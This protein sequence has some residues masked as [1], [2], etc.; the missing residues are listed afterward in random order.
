MKALKEKRIGLRSLLR[1]GLVILSL[2]ALVFAFASCNDSGGEETPSGPS[3]P[4]VSR[5]KP[6]RIEIISQPTAD[7]YEG[8]PLDLTGLEVRVYYDDLNQNKTIT[9]KDA[10]FSTYPP[11]AVGVLAQK[12]AATGTPGTLGYDPGTAEWVPQLQYTLL[13][14]SAEADKVFTDIIDLSYSSK[15]SPRLPTVWP[16]SRAVTWTELDESDDR[17]YTY[18]GTTYG[19]VWSRGLNLT[20]PLDESVYVDDYPILSKYRLQAEYPTDTDEVKKEIDLVPETEW[21]ILPKYNS[22]RTAATGDLLITVGRNPLASDHPY[23]KDAL[24]KAGGKTAYAWTDPA[25]TASH[26]YKEV[27]IVQK[28]DVTNTDFGDFFYWEDDTPAAWLGRLA[29]ANVTVTYSGEGTNTRTKTVE[30]L[31]ELNTVWANRVLWPARGDAAPFAI[32]GIVQSSPDKATVHSKNRNPQVTLSYR[33]AYYYL[34]VPVLTRLQSFVVEPADGGEFVGVD[35]R[36]TDNDVGAMNAAK[37]DKL[38]KATATYIA[39]SDPDKVGTVTTTFKTGA[40]NDTTGAPAKADAKKH[41][42]NFGTPSTNPRNN[43][44]Q[45]AVVFYYASPDLPDDDIA[46]IGQRRMS[47]RVTVEWSHIQQN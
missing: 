39:F 33:G 3:G 35:M 47:S 11:Y 42:N 5:Y 12:T 4:S 34:N 32:R 25:L 28:I 18:N 36:P 23:V 10:T 14:Y 17:G 29:E 2:F 31:W 19:Y 21:R 15:T 7:S 40:D 8:R 16:V 46:N 30:E 22:D 41:T 38:V 9:P 1:R 43:G 45:V 13:W 27:Y 26:P 24:S 20:G 37:F 44:R 6:A